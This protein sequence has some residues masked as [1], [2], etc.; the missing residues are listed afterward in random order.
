MA[1]R[2]QAAPLVPATFARGGVEVADD[3]FAVAMGD[4]DAD[5]DLDLVAVNE[6]SDTVS[7]ALGHGDGTF[8][9]D[10]E[11]ATG[12]SPRS[13]VVDDLDGDG[14]L[15]LATADNDP[16]TVSVLLGN[17]DGTF[18][19]RAAV[20]VPNF[21]RSVT[22]GDVDED[23][24]LD[25]AVVSGA[26]HVLLGNGDGTFAGS[27]TVHVPASGLSDDAA[28]AD[29]DGDGHLD[30]VVADGSA[31]RVTVLLGDGAGAF[32][33]HATLMTGSD[34]P[35]SV[36][37]ADLNGDDDLD[38]VATTALD[39]GVSVFIGA[40][41]GS[42]A[43]RVEY[44]TGARPDAAAAGDLNGDT[45]V[46]LAVADRDSTVFVLLGNGDG[47][48]VA[49]GTTVGFAQFGTDVAI[50]DLNSDS[51]P[52]VAV[53]N[54]DNFS[55]GGPPDSILVMVN[56]VGLALDA[57]VA[58][59]GSDGV[60]VSWTPPDGET[61]V[62][63]YVVRVEPF[64]PFVSPAVMYSSSTTSAV[65][66][67]LING[68]SY[69]FSVAATNAVGEGPRSAESDPVVS[70][71]GLEAPTIGS[72]TQDGNGGIAVSWTAPA[73]DG[74]SPVTAY[75]VT[76]YK[77]YFPVAVRTFN[78][79][80]TTQSMT[81]LVNG[82]SYRFRV[83]ALNAVGSSAYSKVTNAIVAAH[84]APQ[85]P[86]DVTAVAGDGQATVSWSPP[87]LDGGSAVRAYVVTPYVGYIAHPSFAFG[88]PATT[89]TIPVTNGKTYR[90]R[91]QAE[92]LVGTG[93]YS[94][95]SNPVTPTA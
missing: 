15:D 75:V 28:L 76:A 1:D 92:N 32:S 46:D 11:Y 34:N 93:P 56:T 42:F 66:T 58:T 50:G 90:F 89:Q 37:V 77:G 25:L 24:D 14:D 55:E 94:K 69:T 12:N 64:D 68:S 39:G 7:V 85:A 45:F 41:G 53:T 35:G 60:T 33:Q 59:P 43:S 38:I 30:L 88:S 27:Y 61:T 81:N 19:A 5:G 80:A 8:G 40:G 62:T 26:A 20:A 18:A 54:V 52:D 23:G 3:A 82:T 4:L 13:V 83:R 22:T 31:G 71:T 86:T 6:K 84:Q 74:G 73:A 95:V 72:A 44:A 21:A 91:V 2:A 65:V 57:P 48:F 9:T 47:T 63:G 10:V 29:V 78:S 49:S 16:G 87:A 17:G 51:W 67:G 79:I 70:A 36:T